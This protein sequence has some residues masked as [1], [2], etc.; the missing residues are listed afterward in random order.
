MAKQLGIYLTLNLLGIICRILHVCTFSLSHNKASLQEFL[1]S[2]C[3]CNFFWFHLALL[4]I[5]HD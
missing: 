4:P 5:K 2:V 1:K 3:V